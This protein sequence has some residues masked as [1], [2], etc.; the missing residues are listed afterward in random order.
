MEGSLGGSAI[1]VMADHGQSTP[2]REHH[3]EWYFIQSRR[4][5][6]VDIA[7]IRTTKLPTSHLHSIPMM[8]GGRQR[9]WSAA[10]SGAAWSAAAAADAH[11]VFKGS[12]VE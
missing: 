10:A 8:D 4:M 2:S 11:G 9:P 1:V 5:K 12:G 7:V 3:G 6:K